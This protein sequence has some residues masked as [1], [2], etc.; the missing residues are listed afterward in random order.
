MKN[1]V[2]TFLFLITLTCFAQSASALPHNPPSPCLLIFERVTTK[3]RFTRTVERYLTAKKPWTFSPVQEKQFEDIYFDSTLTEVEQHKKLYDALIQARIESTHPIARFFL[4]SAAKDAL[5]QKSI[6]AKTTG[7]LLRKF[8]GPHYNPVYNRISFQPIGNHDFRDLLVTF[9][10]IEHAYERNANLALTPAKILIMAQEFFMVFPTSITPA[11]TYYTE[12]RAI[13]SQWEFARR[14]PYFARTKL[15]SDMRVLFL[16]DLMKKHIPHFL[17]QEISGDD[18][19]NLLLFSINLEPDPI[20]SHLVELCEADEFA[21]AYKNLKPGTSPAPTSI[22]PQKR[23]MIELITLNT[24]ATLEFS[25]LTREDFLKNMTILHGYTA[26]ELKDD[27]YFY[28]HFKGVLTAATVFIILKMIYDHDEINEQTYIHDI[29]KVPAIDFR[30]I[31]QG[32]GYLYFHADEIVDLI[33][34]N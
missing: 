28:N 26:K 34:T 16:E 27:H 29:K 25:P 17:N 33:N 18:L 9:H 2:Q 22:K 21:V 13:G 19:K 32:L 20:V 31:L 6:Y 10:E 12:S 8:A 23:T 7:V 11:M 15:R 3:D 4:R 1:I 24:L 30:W 5:S 14:I